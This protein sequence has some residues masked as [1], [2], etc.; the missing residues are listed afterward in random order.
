MQRRHAIPR[1]QTL[2][3]WSSLILELYL[4]EPLQTLILLQSDLLIKLLQLRFKECI[5]LHEEGLLTLVDAFIVLP[6]QLLVLIDHVLIH[7]AHS[8][9]LTGDS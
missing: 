3:R 8:F 1:D 2:L 9:G 5:L 6:Y 4:V 7:Q